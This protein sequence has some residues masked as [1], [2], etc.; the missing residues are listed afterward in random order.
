MESEEDTLFSLVSKLYD[1]ISDSFICECCDN[2]KNV[3]EVDLI[4]EFYSDLK[5]H[6]ENLGQ[7]KNYGAGLKKVLPPRLVAR[8][9][10]NVGVLLSLDRHL[11]FEEYVNLFNKIS[12]DITK[13][14]RI[15]NKIHS[16]LLS[17]T[18]HMH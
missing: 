5:E 1:H 3:V 8:F 11:S 18:I 13:I 14:L 12:I 17:K 9:E 7:V 2:F 4:D 6:K 15:V 16:K 10:A